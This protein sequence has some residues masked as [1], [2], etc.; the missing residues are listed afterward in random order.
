MSC[1]DA[2]GTP[3]AYLRDE[4]RTTDYHEY[5]R[6]PRRDL[7]FGRTRAC[8]SVMAQ[9]IEERGGERSGVL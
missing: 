3:V 4:N 7:V 2:I 6:S 9:W 8:Q 5:H 1:S